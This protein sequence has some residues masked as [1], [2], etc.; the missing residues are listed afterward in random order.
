MEKIIKNC[1]DTKANWAKFNP[2]IPERM[3]ALETDS[4]FFK[5]GDGVKTY[6]EL[7]YVNPSIFDKDNKYVKQ[8]YINPMQGCYAGVKGE[9]TD[10]LNSPV[11]NVSAGVFTI[12]IYLD[13]SDMI[14]TTGH[15]L[16]K[17][18]EFIDNR[19]GAFWIRHYAKNDTRV[20]V[21]NNG[22]RETVYKMSRKGLLTLTASVG[23][24]V[25][26]FNGEEVARWEG[27]VVLEPMQL[28]YE[29]QPKTY[30]CR[31]FNF[32]LTLDEAK[33]LWNGGRWWEVFV[34][35]EYR[36]INPLK[37]IQNE[38]LPSSLTP[39]SWRDTAGSSD[40]LPPTPDKMTL[41]TELPFQ[42][43]VVGDDAPTAAPDFD[44]QIYMS[45]TNRVFIAKL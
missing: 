7:P 27:A 34:G 17:G 19:Q 39:T 35:E 1:G 3:L 37:M 32:V 45:D 31:I 43:I 44:G 6:S 13:N 18:N 40:L 22:T 10:M 12:S 30:N 14:V 5:F 25:V 33:S 9:L 41:V 36:G 28:F 38:Y 23:G 42:S 21:W 26:Y 15:Y 29:S 4:N 24:L 20:E 8:S 16:L 11:I 2:V